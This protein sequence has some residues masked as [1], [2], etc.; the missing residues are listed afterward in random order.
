MPK[1]EPKWEK[2]GGSIMTM[3]STCRMAWCST[4]SISCKCDYEDYQKD[5][6]EFQEKVSYEYQVN[7]KSYYVELTLN[8]YLK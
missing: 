2:I 6:D 1:N 4:S 8:Y 5:D 3:C 7:A